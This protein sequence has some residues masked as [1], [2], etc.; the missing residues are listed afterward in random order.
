MIENINLNKTVYNKGQYD[1]VINTSFTQLGVPTPQE[2][3][4]SQPTVDDF[5]TMYNNLFYDIPEL[6]ETN[7]HEY[8]IQ[9]SSDYI[10]YVPNLEEIIALQNEI[11]QLR[12][13]LLDSQKQIS[14]LQ[15]Q[16]GTI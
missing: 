9:K 1:K 11:A 16:L 12:V 7:S 4:A 14:E 2:Q 5:F 10:N 8:L 13:E 3:I 15:L 6:G